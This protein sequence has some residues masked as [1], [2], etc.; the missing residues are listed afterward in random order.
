[1][2]TNGKEYPIQAQILNLD[3]T[4]GLRGQIYTG[5]DVKI[6]GILSASIFGHITQGLT[7]IARPG[8]DAISHIIRRNS[9]E[10]QKTIVHVK[11]ET[12]VLIYFNKRFKL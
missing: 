11:R 3:K 5:N 7:E 2:I 12:F 4:A 6:V 10:N 8:R 9:Q 1:M